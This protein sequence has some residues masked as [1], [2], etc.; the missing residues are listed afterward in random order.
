MNKWDVEEKEFDIIKRSGEIA[1]ALG[2]VVPDLL[3][4]LT[5]IGNPYTALSVGASITYTADFTVQEVAT[6]DT[7][8]LN[9][10]Y[11]STGSE[12][13]ATLYNDIVQEGNVVLGNV[14]NFSAFTDYNAEADMY[15]TVATRDG[16]RMTAAPVLTNLSIG[17]DQVATPNGN[18]ASY[19]AYMQNITATYP[20][21]VVTPMPITSVSDNYESGSINIGTE[22]DP[23]YVPY[24]SSYI[25]FPVKITCE[26][27]SYEEIV[28]NG[29]PNAETI[30]RRIRMRLNEDLTQKAFVEKVD[31]SY[32]D[33]WTITPAPMVEQT[34]WR[35]IASTTV[36]F[37]IIDRYIE[38]RGGVVT[39]V[40]IEDTTV[41]KIKTLDNTE[42]GLG[43]Q[44]E[45]PDH[46]EPVIP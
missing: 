31:G 28:N 5:T 19:S 20:R 6:G 14:L 32:S 38:T 37:D 9:F 27:G 23:H 16:Y 1:K 21:I 35:S 33:K 26:S 3:G 10:S 8:V 11:T 7:Q 39:A 46:E 29:T 17:V 36:T 30:L 22:A 18:P 12:D 13:T 24:F 4:S 25:K 15:F 40:K 34:D 2:E 44:V 42:I 41:A 43:Q 45:R